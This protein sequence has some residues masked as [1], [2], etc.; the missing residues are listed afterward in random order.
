MYAKKLQVGDN[1][2]KAPQFNGKIRVG[3]V[4]NDG[5]KVIK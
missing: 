1:N 2:L 4:K 5:I 3:K